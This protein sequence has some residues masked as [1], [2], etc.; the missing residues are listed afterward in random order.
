MD[1]RVGFLIE[2]NSALSGLTVIRVNTKL[3]VSANKKQM[4]L[5]EII[6]N[7]FSSPPI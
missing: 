5:N 1:S 4:L 3:S 6:Y 2:I 7:F